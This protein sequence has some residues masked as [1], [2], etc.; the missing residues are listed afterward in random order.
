MEAPQE[1]HQ[2][3]IEAE[4]EGLRLVVDELPDEGSC[5][6]FVYD[7]GNCE[8][9]WTARRMNCETAKLAAVEFAASCLFAGQ[10]D[11]KPTLLSEMLV[12]ER[13]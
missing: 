6:L 9:L 3:R 11:L 12:W 7:V 13:A 4:W 8:V 10:Q 1:P 5:Q 2:C